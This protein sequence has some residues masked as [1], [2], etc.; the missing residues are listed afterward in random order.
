MSIRR[1]LRVDRK[2]HRFLIEPLSGTRHVKRSIFKAFVSFVEKLQHSPKEVVRK[3]IKED[4]RSTTGS[5]IRNI[6]LDCA[7]DQV[8]PFAKIDIEKKDFFPAPADSGWKVPLIRKLINMRDGDRKTSGW[9]QEEM[10]FAFEY[11][12]T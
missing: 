4:C 11:L 1:M 3:L 10:D 6:N 12:C 7:V 9:T 8:Q 2:T 5:N